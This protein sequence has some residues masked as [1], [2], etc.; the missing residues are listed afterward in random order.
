MPKKHVYV[1]TI[2]IFLEKRKDS[3]PEKPLS[4]W[5]VV[6]G[7]ESGVWWPTSCTAWSWIAGAHFP[8]PATAACVSTTPAFPRQ[9]RGS[10]GSLG[11]DA[12]DA[13]HTTL[14][15]LFLVHPLAKKHRPTG[16]ARG[17]LQ[18]GWRRPRAA[19]S[20][21]CA[22]Q[23]LDRGESSLAVRKERPLQSITVCLHVCW[24]SLTRQW[25]LTLW[26]L[27][28][29]NELER[30]ILYSIRLFFSTNKSKFIIK[31][32]KCQGD[33]KSL[34]FNYLRSNC[35]FL[36]FWPLIVVTGILSLECNYFLFLG[37][38]RCL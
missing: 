4:T 25:Y 29:T 11:H 14:R 21:P 9:P 10:A 7:W 35:L 2:T 19:T 32:Y 16:H 31:I 38:V 3:L 20:G 6:G 15:T 12:S 30:R 33:F 1:Y 37:I 8:R 26:S 28:F 34:P 13:Q 36:I 17:R 18:G 22:A 5:P 24:C 27:I 23:Q